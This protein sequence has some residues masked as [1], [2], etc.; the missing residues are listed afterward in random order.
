MSSRN[1]KFF[2]I[3]RHHRSARIARYVFYKETS[4]NARDLTF[5]FIGGFLGIGFISLISSTYFTLHD[6][7][8]VIGSFGASA[9]LIYGAHRSPLAQARNLIGGHFISAIVGVTCYKLFPDTLWLSSALA[10][11]FSIMA[12][13]ITKTLHPPGGA[14]ALIANIG[15]E[16]VKA[17]GYGYAIAPV[18]VGVLILYTVARIVNRQR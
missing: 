6:S 18:L 8:F 11:S 2:K 16:K 13:Q 17:L 14:T 1:Y 4:V 3:K 9:V 12:M 7:V 10:V 5:T 15:S